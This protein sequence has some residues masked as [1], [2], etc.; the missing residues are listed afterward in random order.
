MSRTV[1]ERTADHIAESAQQASHAASAVVDAMG[2][3]SDVM[4]RVVKQKGDA[5]EELL[6]DTTERVRRY[7]MLSVAATL[8]IGVIA[9]VL[10]SGMTKR[11]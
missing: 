10:I 1:I 11:T 7:P 4:R 9:G 8:A 3:C 6:H 5:A 2:D